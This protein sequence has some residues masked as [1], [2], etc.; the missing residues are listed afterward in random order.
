MAPT[1]DTAAA[2]IGAQLALHDQRARRRL[3]HPADFALARRMRADDGRVEVVDGRVA[4]R[5]VGADAGDAGGGVFFGQVVRDVDA[6]EQLV[7]ALVASGVPGFVGEGVGVGVEAFEGFDDEGCGGRAAACAAG[8]AAAGQAARAFC[9]GFVAI[10]LFRGWT[11]SHGDLFAPERV[12]AEGEGVSVEVGEGGFDVDVFLGPGSSDLG[13]AFA[14]V[15]ELGA[16][17]AGEVVED[18]GLEATPEPGHR[19]LFGVVWGLALSL[20][21]PV[22]GK[23][24]RG[25]RWQLCR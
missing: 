8:L 23:W 4:G 18:C 24:V 22:G 6:P 12:G 21:V 19:G 17:G 14:R 5:V 1:A 3:Q 2:G 9:F 25:S 20:R 16:G 15:V 7:G 11:G 10:A 13:A